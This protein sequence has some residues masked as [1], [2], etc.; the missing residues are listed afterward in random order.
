MN[1][2]Q[3]LAGLASTTLI[4][5]FDPLAHRWVRAV[6]AVGGIACLPFENTPPLDGVIYTDAATRQSDSTDKGNMVQVMPCAVLRPAQWTTSP[7]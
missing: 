4:I 3:M 2:R 1:R 5:G 6:E 7:P